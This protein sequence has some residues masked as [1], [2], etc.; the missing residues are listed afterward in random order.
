MSIRDE[1][2]IAFTAKPPYPDAFI[3]NRPGR[4]PTVTQGEVKLDLVKNSD[5]TISITLIGAH[6]RPFT[7]T[8][9][10]PQC[11]SRGLLVTVTWDASHI[12]LYLNGQE[13]QTINVAP[14]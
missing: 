10:I 2:S 5:R 1:G 7:F 12:T 14:H 8:H 13:T 11:D 6:N 4:F 9:P 3:D